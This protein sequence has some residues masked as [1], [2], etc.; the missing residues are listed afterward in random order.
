MNT[1][2]DHS[3]P[4]CKQKR[5]LRP[6]KFSG[7]SREKCSSILMPK[8]LTRITEVTASV[9]NLMQQYRLWPAG[10]GAAP[11]GT[12]RKKK[13]SQKGW[14]S[15]GKGPRMVEDLHRWGLS[16]LAWT[17]PWET[18]CS[19]EQGV[20]LETSR[21][22]FWLNRFVVIHPHP[23]GES[24]GKKLSRDRSSGNNWS[25]GHGLWR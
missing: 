10:W 14:W 18:C 21:G 13:C 2:R 22:S 1:E 25:E 6:D 17:W 20:G 3:I 12:N 5:Y 11:Q 23:A 15:H 8:S 7:L 19:C 4:D 9:T 16:R 24:F